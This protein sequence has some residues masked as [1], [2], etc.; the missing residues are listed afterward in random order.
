MRIALLLLAAL[1]AALPAAAQTVQGRAVDRE[2]QQPI[3]DASVALVDGEGEAVATGRTG[4][5][6]GFRLTARQAGDYRVTATR[7]GY[8]TLLSA[9]VTLGEGVVVPVEVRVT[10]QPVTLDTAV[11]LASAPAGISGRVLEAESDRPVAGATVALLNGRGQPV[12]D[13][14]T[15]ADG[16]FHLRVGEAGSH[17]LRA[18]R[19]GFQRATS[20]AL[21]VTPGDTLQVEMRMSTGTVVLAPLTVVAASRS[22]MRDRQMAE[23]DWRRE[24]QPWGRYLGPEDIARINPFKASDV[25]Q[26]VPFVRVEGGLYRVVTLR[27]P[28]GRGRCLPTVYVDGHYAPTSGGGGGGFAAR[29]MGAAPPITLDEVVSGTTIAAVEVYDRPSMAPAE[30]APRGGSECGVVVIWTRPPGQPRG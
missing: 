25:M 5:D 1:A 21:T 30:Y 9:V 14:V 2:T 12:R 27:A 29:R 20:P 28:F 15:D 3:A 22:V 18:Q 17:Q 8:R 26:Q 24:N 23:F 4:P 16:R 10:P 7:I 19:V 13:A 11:A 6:G